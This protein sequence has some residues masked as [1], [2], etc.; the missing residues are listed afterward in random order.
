M[1]DPAITVMAGTKWPI[2]GRRVQANGCPHRDA[3][4]RDSA[5]VGSVRRGGFPAF[6]WARCLAMRSRAEGFGIPF[7]SGDLTFGRVGSIKWV[8]WGPSSE[9]VWPIETV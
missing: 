5:G 8:V 9:M 3:G 1:A 4:C 2:S 6:C 7:K